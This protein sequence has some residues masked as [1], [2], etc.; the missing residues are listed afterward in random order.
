MSR[1][2][3]YDKKVRPLRWYG[4]KS[5]K[6]KA[7]WIAGLLPWDWQSLYVE[8]HGGMGSV[9]GTRAPVKS[10]VF[11][12][13]DDR[14]Y[15][16]YL[17]MRLH[18]D[19]FAWAVQCCPHSRKLHKWA[20]HVVGDE[21]FC[22]FDRAVAFHIVALQTS[23][24][25]LRRFHWARLTS[26][27]ASSTGRWDSKRLAVVADRFWNVQLENID[28]AILLDRTKDMSYAVVY[29]DPPYI[30]AYTDSYRV[31]QVD[32]EQLS[33]LLLSQKGK[34]AISG[35]GDEWEQLGWQRHEFDT[36]KLARPNA[37]TQ[38]AQ[39]YTEVLWTN[40]D[41]YK[42]GSAHQDIPQGSLFDT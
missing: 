16:Y 10:E 41:A 42:H 36:V 1:I 22:D 24:Q 21:N 12:D 6:G 34:V 7:E 37:D 3:E 39:P 14:V 20:W 32:T 15:N 17:Q 29:V 30:T 26:A 33:Q 9:L 35:C 27:V 25:N 38:D 18:K 4:G 11:N 5:A 8:T 23:M 40:Y 19:K 28:A 13:L 31:A 2:G